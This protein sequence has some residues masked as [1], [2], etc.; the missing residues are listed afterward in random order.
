MPRGRL[1]YISH[2]PAVSN[3]SIVQAKEA[4][5][6]RKQIT[7]KVFAGSFTG[8]SRAVVSGDSLL[9]TYTASV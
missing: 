9:V 3:R 6:E 5:N 7:D 2:R 1:F 4:K 8:G